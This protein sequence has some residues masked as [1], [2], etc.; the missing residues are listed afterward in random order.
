MLLLFGAADTA[1]PIVVKFPVPS[2]ATIRSNLA[3]FVGVCNNFRSLE[4]NQVG[5]PLFMRPYSGKTSDLEDMLTPGTFFSMTKELL[6][7]LEMLNKLLLIVS[8]TFPLP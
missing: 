4:D 8:L 5:N 7:C 1:S 2:L 3:T 6:T